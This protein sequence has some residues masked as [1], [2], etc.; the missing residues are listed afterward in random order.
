MVQMEPSLHDLLDIQP[1]NAPKG[2]K[3]SVLRDSKSLKL[4]YGG[5]QYGSKIGITEYPKYGEISFV[6]CD[7]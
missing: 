1:K 3:C 7:E 4:Q 6:K 5:L 2:G